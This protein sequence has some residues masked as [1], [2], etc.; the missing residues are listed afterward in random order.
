MKEYL[1]PELEI[2]SLMADENI[3]TLELEDEL[4]LSANPFNK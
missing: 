4:D 3:A 1:K 2:V